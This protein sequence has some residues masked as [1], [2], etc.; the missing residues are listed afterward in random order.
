MIDIKYALI[1]RL[2][3]IEVANSNATN[4][5]NKSFLVPNAYLKFKIPVIE[6][7]WNN[8]AL[9]YEKVSYVPDRLKIICCIRIVTTIYSNEEQ[10]TKMKKYEIDELI[11]D[12]YTGIRIPIIMHPICL[13]KYPK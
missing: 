11:F 6:E 7:A 3:R 9:F 5:I 12:T 10:I 13:D 4:V 1:A 2:K 8:I